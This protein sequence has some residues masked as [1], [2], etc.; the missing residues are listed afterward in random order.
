MT[1]NL[2]AI[3]LITLSTLKAIKPV[4]N[5]SI[6]NAS[7]PLSRIRTSLLKM[8]FV[9]YDLPETKVKAISVNMAKYR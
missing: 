8:L 4:E 7:G 5:V 1:N 6:Q 9:V 3:R 2:M